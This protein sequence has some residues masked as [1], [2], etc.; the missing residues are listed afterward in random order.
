MHAITVRPRRRL[1][2]GTGCCGALLLLA[3]PWCAAQSA[4]GQLG[5]ACGHFDANNDFLLPTL[6]GA[7]AGTSLVVTVA[8]TDP[9]IAG[10]TDGIGTSYRAVGARRTRASANAVG[11]LVGRPAGALAAGTMLR[12]HADLVRADAV[13]CASVTGFADL[14]A[15]LPNLRST[16]AS[17]GM[18]MA[19]ISTHAVP[20]G[21]ASELVFA[22]FTFPA[23]PGPLSS[24][25]GATVQQAE[26]SS[27]GGLCLAA[28]YT[29]GA[30][31][32][33]PKVALATAGVVEWRTVSL[34]LPP[35]AVFKN[36]FE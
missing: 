25:N 31:T 8:S 21:G 13:T 24:T 30:V 9:L 3:S 10:I 2:L 20:A 12:V 15:D 7:P 36:G 27:L 19:P 26:C 16:D 33:A 11:L 29:L 5:I 17:A 14:A 18:D 6:T 32:G 35:D 34:A 4:L 23:D 22:A 28:G 1:R